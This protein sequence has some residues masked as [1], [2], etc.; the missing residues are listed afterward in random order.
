MPAKKFVWWVIFSTLLLSSMGGGV[1]AGEIALT[2]DD[3]PTRNGQVFSGKERTSKIIQ[4][5]K[6]SKVLQWLCDRR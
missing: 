4:D 6:Q 2:L 1:I 3:V 5:L